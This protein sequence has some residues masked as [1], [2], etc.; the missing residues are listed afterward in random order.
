MQVRALL[1][2]A[3]PEQA[4]D[5]ERAA[6]TLLCIG[7]DGLFRAALA[8]DMHLSEDSG[9]RATLRKLSFQDLRAAVN[10]DYSPT[11]CAD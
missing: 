8:P 2:C 5:G 1:L 3:F 10:M 7:C 6:T 11:G 4:V 9:E